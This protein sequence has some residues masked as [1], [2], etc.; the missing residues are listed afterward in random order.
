MSKVQTSDVRQI[1]EELF[2][3]VSLP[4]NDDKLLKLDL[5]H[6]LAFD[7]MDIEDLAEAIVEK[8]DVSRTYDNDKVDVFRC[9]STIENFLELFV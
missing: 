3:Y 6:N 1:L 2:P 4:E 9:N 5:L 8:C 7:S